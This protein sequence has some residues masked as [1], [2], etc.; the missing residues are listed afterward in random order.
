MNQKGVTLIEILIYSF[1]LTLAIT[2]MIGTMTNFFFVQ[3]IFLTREEVTRS[4]AHFLEDATREIRQA[5]QIIYPKARSYSSRISFKR[6]HKILSFRLE[7][8]IIIKEVEGRSLPLTPKALEIK[9]LRFF[10]LK[11]SPDSPSSVKIELDVK[12]RNPLAIREYE[13]FTTYQ[14][15]V[16]Q[17]R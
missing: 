16:T 6:E 15:T 7:D 17:R 13:F 14:T 8:G 12:Y 3:G 2:L 5:D 1:L 4:I 10:H 11:Q 9:T